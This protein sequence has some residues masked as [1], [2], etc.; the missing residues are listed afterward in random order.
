MEIAEIVTVLLMNLYVGNNSHIFFTG[1]KPRNVHVASH[2]DILRLVTCSSPWGAKGGT[3]DKS[4]N[5]CVGGYQK[6]GK[7]KNHW[8][9]CDQTCGLQV[10]SMPFYWQLRDHMAESQVLHIFYTFNYTVYNQHNY[11]TITVK[12]WN[13]MQYFS[14]I[15]ASFPINKNYWTGTTSVRGHNFTLNSLPTWC[16]RQLCIKML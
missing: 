15:K 8:P 7:V 3:C 14:D 13:G 6:W 12:M 11:L 10:R 1:H 2:A 16:P 9:L 5:V 4:K